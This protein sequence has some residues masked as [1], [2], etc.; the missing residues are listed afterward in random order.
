[1]A[2]GHEGEFPP[3]VGILSNGPC[4][5]VNSTDRM[6]NA[7]VVEYQPYEKIRLVAGD[8]AR[9][10]LRVHAGME[11]RDK[12]ELK[13]AVAELELAVRRPTP[14]MVKRAEEILAR[15]KS[16]KPAHRLELPYAERTL[17]AHKSKEETVRA[18]MQAFRIGDLGI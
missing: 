16:A 13:A 6:P 18:V 12:V 17:A 10:V 11:Y 7:E 4:G 1:K 3:C 9:E 2:L 14:E 8:L 15:P 5:D